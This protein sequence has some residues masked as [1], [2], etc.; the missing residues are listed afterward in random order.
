MFFEGFGRF[1]SRIPTLGC[2]EFVLRP[3]HKTWYHIPALS[4]FGD[5]MKILLAAPN[6]WATD[7]L[8]GLL[9]KR[10]EERRVGKEC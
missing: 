5:F 3:R 1:R 7:A 2:A 6:G 9:R 8:C 4:K 10:S